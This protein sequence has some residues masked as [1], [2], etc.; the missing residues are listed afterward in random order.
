MLA[1]SRSIHMQHIQEPSFRHNHGASPAHGY[2]H[3]GLPRYRRALCAVASLSLTMLL[4]GCVS[5]DVAHGTG[6]ETKVTVNE[7]Q[8]RNSE[9]KSDT[10]MKSDWAELFNPSDADVNLDGY[11][12]SDDPAMPQKGKLT[13]NAVLPARGFLVLWLDD[14]NS[15]QT[16][17]HFP[18]KL[19]GNGDHFLLSDPSGH[20]VKTVAMPADPTGTDVTL[21]DV[22]YG[23]YPDGSDEFHWCATPTLG[24]PNAADCAAGPDAGN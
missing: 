14:T 20:I 22:S 5:D 3:G 7:L 15:T 11:F 19:S 17:L 23:A 12:I 18:F 13:I 10:G 1:I 24:K 6:S 16:P 4:G 21:P 2:L 9:I 8:S